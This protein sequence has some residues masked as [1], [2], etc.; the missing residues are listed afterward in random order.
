MP[1]FFSGV[2]VMFRNL[3]GVKDCDDQVASE[4]E[5]AGIEVNVMPLVLQGEVPTRIIGS[6][7]GWGFTRSWRYWVCKGPGLE[8]DVAVPLHERHGRAVRVAGHCGCPHPVEW[9]YGLA[10]GL[11]HV[12]SQEGLNALAAAIESVV[13]QARVKYPE[14]FAKN[15]K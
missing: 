8:V 7:H 3:A 5:S 13:N 12:D 6:L 15:G 11:Y 10:V 4:L 1:V 2:D 14:E 9:H